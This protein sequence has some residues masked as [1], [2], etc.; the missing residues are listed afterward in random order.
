VTGTVVSLA[1][2]ATLAAAEVAVDPPLSAEG[3]CE[4][5]AERCRPTL[6]LIGDEPEVTAVT[7]PSHVASSLLQVNGLG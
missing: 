4:A 5:A 1:A 2:P 3:A 6:L 7:K